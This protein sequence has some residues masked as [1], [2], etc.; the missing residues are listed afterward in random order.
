M[1]AEGDPE[2]LKILKENTYSLFKE[3]LFDTNF[4]AHEF[5]QDTSEL[6]DYE[7]SK[8]IY[9]GSEAQIEQLKHLINQLKDYYDP[10]NYVSRIL[11]ILHQKRQDLHQDIY[12]DMVNYVR[13][14][15]SKK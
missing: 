15:G 12:E 9:A 13:L 5:K 1:L 7:K 8:L 3:C 2:K 11:E 4:I 6:T 14:G 10:R